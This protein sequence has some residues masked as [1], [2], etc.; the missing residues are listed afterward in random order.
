MHKVLY[1][2]Y[3]RDV[4]I[5]CKQ[6]QKHWAV[7]QFFFVENKILFNY[8][9]KSHN[10]YFVNFVICVILVYFV[11]FCNFHFPLTFLPNLFAELFEG[12]FA[13]RSAKKPSAKPERRRTWA[14]ATADGAHPYNMKDNMEIQR[15]R[16]TTWAIRLERCDTCYIYIY[17]LEF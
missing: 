11:S 7:F 9:Y 6:I 8:L 1:L 2:C 3:K 17:I 16:R 4:F 14:A 12:T 5:T 15:M 10:S 13:K